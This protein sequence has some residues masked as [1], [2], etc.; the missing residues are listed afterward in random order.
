MT[1]LK[2]TNSF[3]LY[4]DG[5]LEGELKGPGQLP[6]K[7]YTVLYAN[8]HSQGELINVNSLSVS[9]ACR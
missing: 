6:T 3:L 8:T 2:S 1:Y 9:A 4:V 5:K 7:D